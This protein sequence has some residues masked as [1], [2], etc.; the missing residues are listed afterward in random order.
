MKDYVRRLVGISSIVILGLTVAWSITQA[1][2]TSVAGI[3]LLVEVNGEQLPVNQVS[4]R[5]DGSSCKEVVLQGALLLDSEGRSAAYIG[6]REVC[7]KGGGPETPEKEGSVIF[8][9]TY[10]VSGNQIT[11]E[12]NFGTDEA[13]VKGDVLV[14]ETGGGDRPIE[15]WIFR[16][17]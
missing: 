13:V 6:G 2:D 11:I 8:P 15:K 3:Y 1:D 4:E 12:D 17:E 7:S 9:G 5:L 14:Y 10:T 16:R